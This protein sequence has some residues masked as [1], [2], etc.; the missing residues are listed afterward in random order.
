[1]DQDIHLKMCMGH[2]NQQDHFWMGLLSIV[3]ET[4]IVL[5]QSKKARTEDKID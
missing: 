4:S 3:I 1:M 2:H 5:R